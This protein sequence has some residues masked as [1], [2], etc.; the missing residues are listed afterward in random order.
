MISPTRNSLLLSTPKASEERHSCLSSLARWLH[1]NL[2]Y[3]AG[4]L[5][6]VNLVFMCL[7]LETQGRATGHL[8][9]LQ[10]LVTEVQDSQ[11]VFRTLDVVFDLAFLSELLLRIALD[12]CGFFRS[13]ANWFDMSLVLVGVCDICLFFT[14]GAES[15]IAAVHVIRALHTLRAIRLLRIFRLFRGI[16][17]SEAFD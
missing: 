4:I 3:V 7:E 12:R 5:L 15:N 16:W 13:C 2:N 8:L 11:P 6:G 9:G 1:M 10:S 14:L 17:A